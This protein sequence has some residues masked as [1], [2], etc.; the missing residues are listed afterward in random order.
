VIK[1]KLKQ[2]EQRREHRIEF[3]EEQSA[4]VVMLLQEEGG[5]LEGDKEQE[6]NGKITISYT[7]NGRH[8]LLSGVETRRAV[9]PHGEHVRCGP[10]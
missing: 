5:F 6:F 4:R 10:E 1:T 7:R 9:A 8:L 2:K 3:A